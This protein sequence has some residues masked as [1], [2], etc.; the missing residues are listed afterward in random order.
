MAFTTCS[1]ATNNIASLDDL[2]NDV[3]GLTATQLKALFD[4]FGVDFVAWFNA[5]HIQEANANTLGVMTTQGDIVYRGASAPAR[6]AKGTAGQAL[7]MNSGATAPEWG[8]FGAFKVGSFTRDENTV[9]GTQ[10]ITGVGFTPRAVIFFAVDAGQS[11][12]ASWGFDT[13]TNHCVILDY[14]NVTAG[15]YTYDTGTSI[16]VAVSS[17][18]YYAGYVSAFGADGFTITWTRTGSPGGT[19]VVQYLAIK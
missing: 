14:T 15:R 5:T 9:S 18:N 6:L 2:P 10:A 11:N 4:K 3:G 13:L 17:G 7:L 12:M 19:L 8:L 1:V 16:S